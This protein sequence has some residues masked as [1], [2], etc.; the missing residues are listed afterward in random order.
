MAVDCGAVD[1]RCDHS[2]GKAP[3]MGR[4][5]HG[6]QHVDSLLARQRLADDVEAVGNQRIFELQNGLAELAIERL[7]LRPSKRLQCQLDRA[8]RPAPE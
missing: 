8:R 2:R 3:A 7:R 4:L 5:G 1:Q 6:E